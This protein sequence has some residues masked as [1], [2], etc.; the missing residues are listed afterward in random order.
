MDINPGNIPRISATFIIGFLILKRRR[1]NVNDT[2]RT[3]RVEPRHETI[4]TIRVFMNHF[5][6]LNC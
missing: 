5:V 1:L 4:E 2:A 3:M 6:N